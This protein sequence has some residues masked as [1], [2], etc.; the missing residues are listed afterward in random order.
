[1][2]QSF[3]RAWWNWIK[4]KMKGA[5][6]SASPVIIRVARRVTAPPAPAP[7]AP[8]S[9][10]AVQPEPE[11]IGAVQSASTLIS[12]SEPPE[13]EPIGAVLLEQPELVPSEPAEPASAPPSPIIHPH[14]FG[15][16]DLGSYGKV[17]KRDE[18]HW[19]EKPVRKPRVKDPGDAPKP[20]RRRSKADL[21][22]STTTA[23]ALPPI[24]N[25]DISTQVQVPQNKQELYQVLDLLEQTPEFRSGRY[26]VDSPE[27]GYTPETYDSRLFPHNDDAGI[28]YFRGHLLDELDIYFHMIH[29][30]RGADPD[31]YALHSK[32]GCT[33]EPNL[34]LLSMHR[35]PT[36]WKDIKN[37]P[38]FGCACFCQSGKEDKGNDQMLHMQYFEKI[39]KTP[40]HVEPMEGGTLYE[41]TTYFDDFK[42]HK[43]QPRWWR[44]HGAAFSFFVNVDEDNQV[45]LLKGL[46]QK[47]FKVTKRMGEYAGQTNSGK[48]K[49]RVKKVTDH[50]PYK[51]WGISE[52]LIDWYQDRKTQHADKP[53]MSWDFIS[54][55]NWVASSFCALVNAASK[56]EYGVRVNITN[57]HGEAAALAIDPRRCS[58][59]F[60]DRGDTSINASGRP[61][62]IFHVV[63]PHERIL[64]DGRKINIGMHFRG[65]RRFT[66]GPYSVHITMP[67]LHHMPITE[68]TP[69]VIYKEN[70]PETRDMIY[71][72]EIGSMLAKHID[73]MPLR[74]ALRSGRTPS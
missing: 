64:P 65:M 32:V 17:T 49:T 56:V 44:K 19:F 40:S 15:D 73:G 26:Y 59:F 4:Q 14:I 21:L 2:T 24:L 27:G 57:K 12:E 50:I 22:G 6:R 61:G 20:V 66:W 3:P 18:D 23:S 38:A 45:T 1:M 46:H 53:A 28:F 69:G 16:I 74:K 34:T 11:P 47:Y 30:L 52:F 42:D 71:A 55:D 48:A 43:H 39:E 29:R 5:L 67:G 9:I 10:S 51:E 35:L 41:V 25:Q 54:L 58:Y 33:L 62:R 36:I 31:A 60:Q 63:K 70:E 13:P 37:R 72:S 68:F 7:S 8:T